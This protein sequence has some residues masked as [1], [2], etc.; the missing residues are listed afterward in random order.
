MKKSTIFCAA[1]ALTAA[2]TTGCKE[3]WDDNPVLKTHEGT[4]TVDFLNIPAMQQ[5]PITLTADN[6]DGTFCLTASQ[7]D[8][9]YAAAAAYQVQVSFTEDFAD[10]Y[11]IPQRF[12]DLSDINPLNKDVAEAI[13]NLAGVRTDDDLP[14]AARRVYMRLHAFVPQHEEGTQYLSNAVYYESIAIAK[15]NLVVWLVGEHSGI[16]MRGG[17]NE[18]GSPAEWEFVSAAD[19]NTYEIPGTVTIAKGTEFKVADSGWS[20]INMGAGA[21]AT[22]NIGKPYTLNGG[23]NPGNLVMGADFTG[24]AHLRID[25]E[26]YILTLDE[27]K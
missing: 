1:L 24:R 13:E 14:L 25:G 9:G 19:R 7:P 10:Y 15:G 26:S 6:Q 12:Y 20:S 5:M 18:W 3:T 16:F 17:M 11:E 22:V 4:V 21:D 23:D 27:V 8:F 2:L